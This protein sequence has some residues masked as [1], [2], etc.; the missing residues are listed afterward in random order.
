MPIPQA[1]VER[2]RRLFRFYDRDRDGSHSLSGDFQPVAEEL[3]GRWGDRPTPFPDLLALLLSTYSH[4]VERR[5]L[6]GNGVVDEEEF[7]ASHAVVIEAFGRLPLQARAFIAQSAGRFFDCLDLDG[8]GCLDLADLEAYAS[9]FGQPTG[10]IQSNLA[11]MLAAF[12]LPPDRLPKAVF[13]E[14][15][16]QYWF[17]P[18]GE[19]PGRWLFD[20]GVECHP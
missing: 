7:V 5:D 2:Y 16:A 9:A 18:S 20:L 8:D 13:L 11:R 12:D 19:A 14:L 15:V 10:G 6:D 3:H 4:E 1:L 17:D